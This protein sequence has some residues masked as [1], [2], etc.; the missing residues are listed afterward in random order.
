MLGKNSEMVVEKW[1]GKGVTGFE[2]VV[3]SYGL[4]VW[5]ILIHQNYA[6]FPHPQRL[7][8]AFSCTALFVLIT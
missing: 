3:G 1:R 5:F 4:F 2:S 8:C 6:Q 7:V